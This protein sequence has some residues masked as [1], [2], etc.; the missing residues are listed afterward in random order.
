M[1]Q[2]RGKNILKHSYKEIVKMTFD[3]QHEI[4]EKEW[5]SR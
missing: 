5:K 1:C 3:G 4:L 2:N